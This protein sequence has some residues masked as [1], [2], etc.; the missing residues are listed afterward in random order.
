MPLQTF[1]D[2]KHYRAAVDAAATAIN[3]HTQ[4]KIV[5]RDISDND[6]MNQAFT[7]KPKAGQARARATIVARTTAPP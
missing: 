2:S 7:E 6:V 5:R 1:W 4:N 3:A